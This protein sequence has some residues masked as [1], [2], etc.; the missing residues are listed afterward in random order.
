M[1]INPSDNDLIEQ[2]LLGKMTETEVHDFLVRVEN[3]RELARK[4]RLLKT[5]PEMMSDQGRLEFEKKQAEAAVPV[6]RKRFFLFLKLRTIFW[7]AIIIAVILTGIVLLFLF[8]GSHHRQKTVVPQD[9]TVAPPSAIVKPAVIAPVKDST[10]ETTHVLQPM[11]KKEILVAPGGTVQKATGLLNP[12][13]GA[14]IS[15]K[16]EILFSWKQTADTFSRFYI[17]SEFNNQV[18]LWRGIPP[19]IKEYKVP[20]SSLFPGKYYWYV[21]SKEQKRSFIVIE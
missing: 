18:V 8:K 21:G 3:D 17:I 19:R 10:K 7:V 15:R 20:G 16:D 2:Y 1:S 9:I 13:E 5:F 11:E 12:S 14:E 6:V 4:L